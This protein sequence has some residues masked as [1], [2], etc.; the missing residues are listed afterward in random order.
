M[1]AGASAVLVHHNLVPVR[2]EELMLQIDRSS[3]QVLRVH[4]ALRIICLLPSGASLRVLCVPILGLLVNFI[5]FH[6]LQ[7]QG[8]AISSHI[9]IIG[10]LMV[11]TQ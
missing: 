5:N 3:V 8:I 11:V 9:G 7:N 6:E 2:S 10:S 1:V 4:V